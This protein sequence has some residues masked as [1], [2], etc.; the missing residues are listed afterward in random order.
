MNILRGFKAIAAFILVAALFASCSEDQTSLSISDIPGTAKVIGKLT[1]SEGESYNT[2]TSQLV[3][4][5]IPARGK[6]VFVQV[7]NSSLDPNGEA[8]GYAVYETTTDDKGEFEVEIPAVIDGV[9]VSVRAES[10]TGQYS[11]L[12]RSSTSISGWVEVK[13]D[14]VY[15]YYSSGNY[16]MPNGILVADGQYTYVV[17]STN[18]NY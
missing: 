5:I 6:K 1:Y 17:R 7:S 12:Q 4:N 14:V 8:D 9:S 2:I 16:V 11:E 15:S 10:F 13:K 3:T 18:N